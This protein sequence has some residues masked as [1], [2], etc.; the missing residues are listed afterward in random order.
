MKWRIALAGGLLALGGCTAA[1]SGSA[2]PDEAASAVARRVS[3]PDGGL[4]D[5]RSVDLCSLI[6]GAALREHVRHSSVK[7]AS[8]DFCVLFA[9]VAGTEVRV[10]AALEGPEPDIISRDLTRRDWLPGALRVREPHDDIW[11]GCETAMVFADHAGVLTFGAQTEPDEAGEPLGR[12]GHALRPRRRGAQG[13]RRDHCRGQG[14]ARR[15]R[16]Q[17]ARAHRPV[18]SDDR[19]AGEGSDACRVRDVSGPTGQAPLRLG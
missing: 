4:G 11:G 16:R 1:V 15:L 5:L 19:P 3:G 14:Q 12:P 7:S 18:P 2:V 10:V 17:L 9:R 6:D 8:M 13:R